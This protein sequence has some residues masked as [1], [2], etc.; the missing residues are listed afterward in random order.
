MSETEST[1]PNENKTKTLSSMT[2]AELKKYLQMRG[3]TVNGYLKPALLEIA[4]AVEKMMLPVEPTNEYSNQGSEDTF[5]Y[6]DIVI[7]QPLS[8]NVVNDFTDSPPF[9]L[10][11][12][13]N[14]LIYYSTDYDKQGLAA[15]KSFDDYRLFDEG[16]VES[17]LK[18]TLE[19][20]MH[21][22][23]GKVRPAMK[24]KTDDGKKFYETWFLLEGVGI[25]RGSILNAKCTCKGG[26][27][28]GCKHIAA[29]MY[30]LEDLLNNRESVTSGPCQWVKRATC[31]TKPTD[32]KELQ[33]RK[34]SELTYSPCKRKYEHRFIEHINVDVRHEDDRNPPSKKCLTAF[35]EALSSVSSKPCVLPLL[36]KLYLPTLHQHTTNS[37]PATETRPVEKQSV[38]GQ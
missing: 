13:F 2:V 25:N 27:D 35:T 15:Y 19:G 6:N 1:Q 24:D 4:Q 18:A 37:S 11:D 8:Y 20:S 31:D 22:F 9:G 14:Y 30:S 26:Q 17:L 5:I 16:Y 32:I 36:Q 7:R 12:I 38:E 34:R 33:I 10:Y 21:L 29:T 28:G 23:V 3:V